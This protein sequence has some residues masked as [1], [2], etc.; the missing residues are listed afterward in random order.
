MKFNPIVFALILLSFSQ[1]IFSQTD[2][3]EDLQKQIEQILLNKKADVGVSILGIRKKEMI[4]INGEKFY[5]MLSTV[6]IPIALAIL[7]KV[8]KGELT[9][10]QKIFIKK[11]ELLE[12]PDNWSPFKE[13]FPNG[14]VS[15]SLEEVIIWMVSSSDNNLT[16]I[17]LRLIGGPKT[18]EDFINSKKLIIKNNEEDMHKDWPSQFIN[19]T[20]PNEAISL[21]KNFN[22]GKLLNKEYT[23]WLYKAMVIINPEPTEL[24]ENS[25]NM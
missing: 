8:Q 12:N 22:S 18:V 6:K 19:Q 24:K 21:L 23:E 16:D 14:N 15:I 9:M 25:L 10:N 7:H 13:K 11:E 17:L 3:K 1:N 4:Q 5:P 20:T 2:K